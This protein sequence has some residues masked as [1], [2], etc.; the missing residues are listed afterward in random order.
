MDQV[1][2]ATHGVMEPMTDELSHEYERS[3][4]DNDNHC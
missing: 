3:D 1:I 2:K 4:N